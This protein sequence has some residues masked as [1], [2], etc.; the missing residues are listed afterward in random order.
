M[1]S[2]RTACCGAPCTVPSRPAGGTD[3]GAS[4]WPDQ[5]RSRNLAWQSS[6]EYPAAAASRSPE[7][8]IQVGMAHAGKTVNVTCEH[9]NFRLSFDGETVRVV[10]RTTS[11]EIDR[12]KARATRTRKQ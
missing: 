11:T 12:Y 4:A 7:S 3:R 2:L 5:T 10:P 8:P 1:S 6:G 9:D